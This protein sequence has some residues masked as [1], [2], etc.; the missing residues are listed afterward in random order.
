[1]ITLIL[2]NGACS[3]DSLWILSVVRQTVAQELESLKVLSN[4]DVEE[5]NGSQDL[6]VLR[7]KV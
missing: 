7:R 2:Y 1:M 5:A 4:S 3:Q 6:R